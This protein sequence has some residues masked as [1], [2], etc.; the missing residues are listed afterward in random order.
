MV[1][2]EADDFLATGLRIGTGV[3]QTNARYSSMAFSPIPMDV[4]EW[5]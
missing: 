3:L 2:F 4:G 1:E 5:E